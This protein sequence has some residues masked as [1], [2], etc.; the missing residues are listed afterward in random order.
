MK[1]CIMSPNSPKAIGP[2]SH[3]VLCGNLVYSSGQLPIDAATGNIVVGDVQA[4]TA[5][6]LE[7]LKTV[8]IDCGTSL[9]NV[10]KTTVYIKD[11]SQFSLINEVYAKYF[12]SNFP[13]RTCI[14]VARLPKDALVEIEA[15]AIIT[16]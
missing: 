3:V 6:A 13:A 4:Q 11:M 1:K 14:E 9:E 12:T 15:I 8:F 5:K 16:K 10:I 2:Y 7:N